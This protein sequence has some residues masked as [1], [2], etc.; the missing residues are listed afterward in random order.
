VGPPDETINSRITEL[1]EKLTTALSVVDQRDGEIRAFYARFSALADKVSELTER[2]VDRADLAVLKAELSRDDVNSAQALIHDVEE[3]FGAKIRVL[4]SELTGEL[5][6]SQSRD[7]LLNEIRSEI[8]RLAQRWVQTE[9]SA[10]QTH[11]LI[12]N[13]LAQAA[14]L[15]DGMSGEFAALQSHLTE[16]QERDQRIETLAAD[17]SAR[18]F[19][20]QAE[21]SQNLTMLISRDAEIA[22]L[23]IQV[24]HL[25][26]MATAKSAVP[27]AGPNRLHTAIAATVG[28]GG[29]KPQAEALPA[30]K[31]ASAT[32]QEPGN[33][34]QRYDADSAGAKEEKKQL[35]Q[36]IS[37]DIERVRGELRKRAGVGR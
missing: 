16:R 9:T 33:L 34:L 6:R 30:L 27:L 15:R 26:Q 4:E 8:Q 31:P 22:A 25:A 2:G 37:A 13:E 10:Q 19:D 11:G 14:Q 5:Q 24:E 7:G 20:V 17:L 21:L 32:E 1:Q 3:N 29:V 18:M 28:L 36:R 12:A 23:K 35:Q